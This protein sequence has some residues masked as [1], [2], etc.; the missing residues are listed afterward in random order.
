MIEIIGTSLNQWDTGRE[1][2]VTAIEADRIHFAN[3]GDSKAVIMEIVD[4]K[5]AIPNYLLQTGKQLCVYAVKNG[6]TVDRKVFSVQ[7]RERPENYIYE[8]DQRNYIY[9]LIADA[10]KAAADASEAA[11]K[12][13]QAAK[14]WVLMG[15]AS[16]ESIT[17]DDA[18]YQTFAGFRVFGKTTQNGVPTP[19]APVDLVS[20]ENPTITV[21]DQSAL[22]P[23]TLHGIPVTS[24][25][26]YTDANGQQWICDEIDFARGVYVRRVVKE[27]M[28][29]ANNW[30]KSA[31]T[32]KRYVKNAKA[33][34]NQAPLCTHFIGAIY[35]KYQAGY[36][37]I[38]EGIQLCVDTTFDTLEEWNAFL[39]ANE[40]YVFYAVATPTETPLSAE[41]LAAYAAL[42][43]SRGTTTV[44]NDAGA[45][46]DLVYTMDAK[47]YIDSQISAGIL[48][49]TV[50]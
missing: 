9:E 11:D 36:C 30:Y 5:A 39:S 8:E 48:A 41:E 40:A 42:H 33:K 29:S 26:N 1:V 37:F 38:N 7:K 10:E 22:I 4:G 19:D 18:I 23:Y 27:R 46:M 14:S 43:T 16:G 24:G 34:M 15:E 2:E 47:K 31:N 20:V 12:A 50:E 17:I 45:W 28:S 21:N 44:S 13:N 6:V 35:Y 49:A 25:G 3:N 32:A